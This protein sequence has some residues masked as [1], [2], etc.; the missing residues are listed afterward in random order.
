MHLLVAQHAVLV[1][2]VGDFT[3]FV[4]IP[5]SYCRLMKQ[6]QGSN[7]SCG[8]WQCQWIVGFFSFQARIFSAGGAI[9]ACLQLWKHASLEPLYRIAAMEAG[10][11]LQD[12]AA[13]AMNVWRIFLFGYSCII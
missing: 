12:S 10:M 11:L 1:L 13:S 5:F 3:A 2:R 9:L 8:H 7:E 4:G 6:L